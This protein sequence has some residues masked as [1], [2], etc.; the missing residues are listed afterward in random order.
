[1]AERRR[2][3]G[4]TL[5]L[6]GVVAVLTV[7]AAFLWTQDTRRGGQGAP[8]SV[9]RT[10]DKGAAVAYRMYRQVGLRPQIWNEDFGHLRQPGLMI[11]I[12]PEPATKLMGK[13]ISEVGEILPTELQAL[14]QWVRQGNVAVVLSDEEN[15]FFNAVGLIPDAPKDSHS[16]QTAQPD[17]AGVLALGVS[18][19]ETLN[20]FG[21]KFGRR[22][23]KD[24][25]AEAGAEAPP[26]DEVPAEQWLTL[27][28]G[29]DT[30]R[31]IPKVVSASR[32]QGL[33]VAVSDI[34][35]ASNLG[36]L[37]GDN[38]RFML[39][40]AR[41]NPTHGSIWFDEFHK[42]PVERGLMAYMRER[43]LMPFLSYGFVLLCFL[44]WRTG[45]RFGEAEPL[46]ADRRRDSGE[47]V[48]A[49]AALYR[50]AGMP[51]DALAT[52]Y[53]DVGRRAL[54]PSRT[55]AHTLSADPRVVEAARCYEARTGRPAAEVRELLLQVEQALSRPSLAEADAVAL[56]TRLT[57]FDHALQR[58]PSGRKSE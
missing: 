58:H 3:L 33:Y 44:F 37:Q 32:G 1:M 54:G 8:Y 6:A 49:V 41:L 17:Q 30:T 53:A 14:D 51:R 31:K 11:L 23:P 25:A 2:E 22:Q 42:R 9:E 56:C 10:D 12:A 47:Y 43:A 36:I 50:N 20:A 29:A 16:L 55:A 21:F 28:R 39:N 35:P 19:L 7:A 4:P 40:L 38:A 34:Y 46:V 15:S 5:I 26:I 27:F 18:K 52:V 24:A 45:T 13:R 48:R 57:Q